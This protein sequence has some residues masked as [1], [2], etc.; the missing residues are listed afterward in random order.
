MFFE[1]VK[2]AL[3]AIGA[4]KMRSILTVLGVMI[5][6]AAVI[7]VVS[8]VQGMQYQ[9]SSP[10]RER[11]RDLHPRRPRLLRRRAAIRSCRCRRSPTTM[12]V[13]VRRGATAVRDFTPIFIRQRRAEK[14]RHAPRRHALWRQPE[15]SRRR[16]AVRR[17]RP[18]LRHARRGGQEAR[19][20]PRLRS[21]AAARTR[22]TPSAKTSAST[23]TTS[24]SSA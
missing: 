1:N 23:T 22:P 21:G 15:L 18:L 13:A 20:R 3:R 11:R 24:P 10:A 5:G 17:P 9:I 4:N 7:A 14:R 6:V 12:R 16:Q 8:L 19:G 2:I